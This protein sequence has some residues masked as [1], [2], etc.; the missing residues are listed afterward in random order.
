VRAN[1]VVFF[2]P[3]FGFFPDLGETHEAPGIE[4][5]VAV[6]SVEPLDKGILRRLAG[7]GVFNDDVALL[8]PGDEDR[9]RNALRVARPQRIPA[10][11]RTTSFLAHPKNI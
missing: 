9:T 6:D 11:G 1:C 8:A 10:N 4:Y 3:A 7:L 2:Q 5:A